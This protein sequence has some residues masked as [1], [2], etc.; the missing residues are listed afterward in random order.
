MLDSTAY[1]ADELDDCPT[2]FNPPRPA[3][4]F[5]QADWDADGIGDAC[6][7][8]PLVSGETACLP[9]FTDGFESGDVSA[10]SASIP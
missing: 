5:V 1:V 2:V 7:R 6:D 4:G 9:I 8:C 10:W 3:D